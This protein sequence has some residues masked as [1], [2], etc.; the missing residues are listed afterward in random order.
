[1]RLERHRQIDARH[2]LLALQRHTERVRIATDPVGVL[3][4][5]DGDT[6]EQENADHRGDEP[7]GHT[8]LGIDVRHL[9]G[10][11]FRCRLSG[12]RDDLTLLPKPQPLGPLEDKGRTPSNGSQV[13]GV[14]LGEEDGLADRLEVFPLRELMRTDADLVLSDRTDP[15]LT[16]LVAGDDRMPI[17]QPTVPVEP[18]LTRPRVGPQS[19]NRAAT[20]H[21]TLK[22]ERSVHEPQDYIP[23]FLTHWVLA[24]NSRVS[25]AEPSISSRIRS[26]SSALPLCQSAQSPS[27]T[28]SQSTR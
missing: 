27:P 8:L 14:A 1:M 21:L 7:R 22:R 24:R 12:I 10:H 6:G 26:P 17:V 23:A 11:Q 28:A 5:N 25:E 15:D 3:V 4:E 20:G 18:H 16:A 9:T 19:H 2:V 13:N